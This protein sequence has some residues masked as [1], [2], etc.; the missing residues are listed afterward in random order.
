MMGK[1]QSD[2]DDKYRY[3]G[4]EINP[5]RITEFWNS[6]DEK[7]K[8]VKQVQARG[9]QLSILE[10]DSSLLNV[11]LMSQTDKIISYI[12]AAILIIA[13]FLPVYSIDPSGKAISGSAISFF[14][15][16]PFIG[17]YVAWGG[18]GMILT[19]IVFSLILLTCP[20]AGV[21]NI[22]GLLNKN[23]GEKYLETVKRYSRFT[24]VPILLYV[25]LLV[26]LL[27]A[28][29]Q[30]FGSLGIEAVGESLNMLAIFTMTGVGFWLNIVGLT[31][32]FA[33]A[34]GL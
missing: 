7:K 9:G 6:E 11:K 14:L 12:G 13:F 28:G 24:F 8:Y 26:T 3:L 30:P 27:F 10:R 17:S 2:P 5:G 34:R 18:I 21:F 4:F 33:Q 22:L 23:K 32:G 25:V 15:N 1:K 19:V 20:V 16:L 29:P 31:I